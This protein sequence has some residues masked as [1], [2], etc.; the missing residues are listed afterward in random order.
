MGLLR[1][2]DFFYSLRFLRLL[3]TPWEKTT[4]FKEGIVD[5][6]G[7]KLKKPENQSEKAAYTTFHRLVF[8][9]KR[10]LNKLPLGKTKLASY[11]TAFF[12]IKEHTGIDDK[13]LTK[14]IKESTGVDINCLQL[15]EESHWFLAEDNKSIGANT[16]T[17]TQDL[18]LK[19]GEL[20]AKKG[21]RVVVEQHEPVGNT[22]G[23]PVFK[24]YHVKTKQSIYITQDDI[25]F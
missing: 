10:M 21:T 20:L 1:T 17:L 8:N 14:V 19:N 7:K 15:L 22:L 23:I 4:A 6:D 5:K 3:T 13:K 12:L 2:S 18:P 9:L 11:A 16:Y 24:G 25:T